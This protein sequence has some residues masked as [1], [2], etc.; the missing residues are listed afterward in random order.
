[1][2]KDYV[3]R[4]KKVSD[5]ELDIF[6]KSASNRISILQSRLAQARREQKTRAKK[7]KEKSQ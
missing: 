5:Q 7:A 1:M 4:L 6:I 3:S 2:I